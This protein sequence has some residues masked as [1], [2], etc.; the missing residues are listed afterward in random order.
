MLA[1]QC[2][3]QS[4]VARLRVVA[5]PRL[6]AATLRK[7]CVVHGKTTAAQLRE[8]EAVQARISQQ[9]TPVVDYL[10]ETSPY[11]RFLDDTAVTSMRDREKS[12][13]DANVAEKLRRLR[14]AFANKGRKPWN[15]GKHHNRGANAVASCPLCTCHMPESPRN[16]L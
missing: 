15:V 8:R 12:L 10:L 9:G 1:A 16:S 3:P 11:A 14:I 7:S 6:Q 5:T 2:V 4:S 13:G